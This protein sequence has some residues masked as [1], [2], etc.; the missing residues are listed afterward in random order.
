[1]CGRRRF[2][3]SRPTSRARDA[4]GKRRT[5]SSAGRMSMSGFE[6]AMTRGFDA[7][8]LRE[9][10]RS[11]VAMARFVVS[12]VS[13]EVIRR[14]ARNRP[15]V[16]R[17]FARA[18][19]AAPV[20]CSGGVRAWPT[21]PRAKIRGEI[22]I[23][24]VLRCFEPDRKNDIFFLWTSGRPFRDVPS[25]TVQAAPQYWRG[26]REFGWSKHLSKIN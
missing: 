16:F 15:V 14:A 19:G 2:R 8:S 20:R 6:R 1:M 25:G 10:I 4:R 5:V 9:H 12:L 23:R 3:C 22:E 26:L 21:L 18:R 11:T 24:H 17:S 13:V 7:I